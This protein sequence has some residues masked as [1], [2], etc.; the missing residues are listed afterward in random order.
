MRNP[1][2]LSAGN[3]FALKIRLMTVNEATGETA[4]LTA[5]TV[6]ARFTAVPTGADPDPTAPRVHESLEVE[7]SHISDGWWLVLFERDT[8][9]TAATLDALFADATPYLWI[10]DAVANHAHFPVRY[11]RA[12]QMRAA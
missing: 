3:T 9:P 12:K 2:E 4:P 10:D 1:L 7:A 8:I 5:A 11:V 6:T